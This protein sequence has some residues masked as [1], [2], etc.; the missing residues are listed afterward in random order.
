MLCL[1]LVHSQSSNCNYSG[2]KKK[3]NGPEVAK[4]FFPVE[5]GI[6]FW[7]PL[8]YGRSCIMVGVLHYVLLLEEGKN[9]FVTPRPLT[10]V[11]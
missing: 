3:V 7:A 2:Q 5:E 4:Y 6:F 10:F 8:Y 11:F 9:L 1:D